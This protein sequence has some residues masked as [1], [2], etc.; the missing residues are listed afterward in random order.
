M[1]LISA[2]YPSK[3]LHK[4]VELHALIP[5]SGK[6]PFPVYY[7]LHGGGDDSSNWIRYSQIE[8]YSETS[9]FIVVMPDCY[10]SFCV[11]HHEGPA[12]A[13][14]LMEDVVQFVDRSFHTISERAGRC[15]G[16]I[17]MGGYGAL[18]LA[19]SNPHMFCSANSTA[20]CFGFW[21]DHLAH[22]GMTFDVDYQAL[23]RRIHGPRT[24]GSDLDLF[25]LAEKAKRTHCKMPELRL[26]CG[27][28]DSLLTTNRAYHAHLSALG[29]AHEYA[30]GEGAHNWNYFG[31]EISNALAFHA[32]QLGKPSAPR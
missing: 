9:P 32:R 11:D 1:A 20:G 24:A 16:G 8:L 30:E 26:D 27:L 10:Y 13:R 3:I 14:Y 12:Y 17:S 4:Q 6:G 5:E 28:S 22:W 31:S 23:L 29:I 15:I 2:R 21:D 25:A 7:L 19:I 18:H